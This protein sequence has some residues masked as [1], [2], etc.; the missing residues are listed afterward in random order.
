MFDG[1]E[2][3]LREPEPQQPGALADIAE[4]L[5]V[6]EKAKKRI[7]CH[8]DAY[9]RINALVRNEGYGA[10][11][12][13]IPCAWLEPG[14]VLMMR[15]EADEDAELKSVLDRLATEQAEKWRRDCETWQENERRKAEM[16]AYLTPGYLINRPPL[17]PVV[18]TGL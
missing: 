13:V 2:F 15:S 12:K 14:Q 11:F 3:E 7:L 18:L 6:A 5:Q 17:W 10:Y 8:P 16:L 9:E 1:L 4:L